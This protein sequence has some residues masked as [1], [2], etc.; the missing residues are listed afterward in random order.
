MLNVGLWWRSKDT[1]R[2]S[3]LVGKGVKEAAGERWR[4]RAEKQTAT[5]CSSLFPEPCAQLL[6]VWLICGGPQLSLSLFLPY[7]HTI[8]VNTLLRRRLL[9]SNY[10]LH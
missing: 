9:N 3:W 8:H 1:E 6:L 2:R 10:D 7:T 5:R 4:V